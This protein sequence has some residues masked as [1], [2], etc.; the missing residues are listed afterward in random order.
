MS[1]AMP[2]FSSKDGTGGFGAVPSVLEISQTD[3]RRRPSGGMVDITAIKRR[4][5]TNDI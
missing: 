2:S 5:D 1:A 4:G 3:C